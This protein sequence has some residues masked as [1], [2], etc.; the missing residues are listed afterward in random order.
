MKC[1][2]YVR[3]IRVIG[4]VVKVL[5]R[6]VLVRWVIL[7][8]LITLIALYVCIYMCVC[9]LSPITLITL[10]TGQP[11]LRY[12]LLAEHN[13]CVA[14]SEIM[15]NTR[16]TYSWELINQLAWNMPY[17]AEH[18]AWPQVPFHALPLLNE[19]VYI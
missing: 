1:E 14:G 7:I 11:F 17:H 9:T 13:G 18:H 4:L 8:S 3:V 2:Y 16:T 15:K 19:K 12:Y 6:R 10:F 5:A